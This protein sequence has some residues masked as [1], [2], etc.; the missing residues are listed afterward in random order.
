MGL[1]NQKNNLLTAESLRRFGT[2]EIFRKSKYGETELEGKK[3]EKILTGGTVDVIELNDGA[4]AVMA[5]GEFGA[6]K[7]T[8]GANIACE[9]FRLLIKTYGQIYKNDKRVIKAMKKEEFAK[10]LYKLW[11]EMVLVNDEDEKIALR[12]KQEKKLFNWFGKKDDNKAENNDENKIEVVSE[13]EKQENE[14]E[15][16]AEVET[17]VEVEVEIEVEVETE[18]PK[19][20]NEDILK[21]Y[22]VTVSFAVLTE[23]GYVFA[24]MGNGSFVLYNQYEKSK[25][26]EEIKDVTYFGKEQNVKFVYSTL[27]KDEFEGVLITSNAVERFMP[28]M[29]MQYQYAKSTEYAYSRTRVSNDN[30]IYTSE[31]GTKKD[32]KDV[33][34]EQGILI[35]LIKDSKFQL[36]KEKETE[37]RESR[38]AKIKEN[39]EK[40]RLNIIQKNLEIAKD[41]SVYETYESISYDDMENVKVF[42]ARRQGRGHVDKNIPCQDYC[43]TEKLPKGIVIAVSDGVG[44][45]PKS[46]FGSKFATEA[47]VKIAKQADTG[48][49]TEKEYV[50]RLLSVAFRKKI[51]DEWRR[52]VSEHVR[53]WKEDQVVLKDLEQYGATLLFTV[54]TDNYFV[55]GN[56]GDG[57]IILFNET[58][59]VKVRKHSPKEDTKTKALINLNG[60]AETF[61]TEKYKRSDFSS[62]LLSTDGIYDTLENGIEFY[63]YAKEAKKRFLENDEPYQAFCYSAEEDVYKELYSTRTDDDCTIVLATDI[64]FNEEGK[65]E[66]YNVISEKYNYTMVESIGDVSVYASNGETEAFTTIVCDRKVSKISIDGIKFFD[67]LESYEN[68]GKYF[69]VYKYTSNPNLNR[70]YQYAKIAEQ[71]ERDNPIAS[72]EVLKLYE[73]ILECIQILDNSGYA[74]DQDYA[75]NLMVYTDK[76][77]LVLY[78]EAIILKEEG[79]KYDNKKVLSLFEVLYGKFVCGDVEYPFFKL[80][81]MSMGMQKYLTKTISGYIG[82]IRNVGG[83]LFFENCGNEDWY[84]MED[85][86]IKRGQRIPLREGELFKIK[87]GLKTEIYSFV[88]KKNF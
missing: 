76:S 1:F 68:N 53:T 27:G 37:Y 65:E 73:K 64:S 3:I 63:K 36:S 60:Y 17:D 34:K 83:Q 21:D 12:E 74:L 75:Q 55:V 67:I 87:Q 29:D 78:P 30:F 39:A 85:N 41:K 47:V 16:E 25:V 14:A 54:I 43:L 23:D 88:E 58:E 4:I 6:K 56:I 81:Y 46:D 31:D 40:E 84:D 79:K 70:L 38:L 5:E 44:S 80:D 49:T 9:A 18:Q 42:M 66:R 28:E 48:C 57:Q 24:T 77:E 2:Y 11:A 26:F 8:E 19:L 82:A 15:T 69:N 32:L 72:A 7:G 62:V 86:V 13:T 59:G 35:L 33:I 52:M 45:C 22:A 51:A 50:E 61:I 20:E 10:Q 71:P